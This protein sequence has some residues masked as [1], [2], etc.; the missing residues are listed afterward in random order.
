MEGSPGY[1]RALEHALS[2]LLARVVTRKR[3]SPLDPPVPLDL[4]A[5]DFEHFKGHPVQHTEQAARSCVY[6][7]AVCP[8]IAG[9]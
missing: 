6:R 9:P 3:T 4:V 8:P 5:P 1:H 7:I 2:S